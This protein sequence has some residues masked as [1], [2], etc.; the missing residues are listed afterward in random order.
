[1]KGLLETLL[2]Q[3]PAV[4]VTV[5]AA[6]GS[7]PRG[8]GAHMVVGKGGRLYGTVGG[9]RIEARAIET[10]RSVLD[11]GT[12]LCKTESLAP[13]G[14]MG[15]VCGGEAEL[16]YQPLTEADRP[17][18]TAALDALEHE[19]PARLAF[20]RSTGALALMEGPACPSSDALYTES[21][22]PAGRVYIFGGGHVAQALVPVLAAVEFRC[23]VLEDRPEFC[24]RRLFPAA[25]ELRLYPEGQPSAALTAED[26]VCVMTR[27]HRS[28]LEC[29]AFALRSPARYIGVM[30]SRN[31][32][33]TVNARLREMGFT[34]AELARVHT[35]IGLA[36]GAQTPAEIAVSIAAE[37]IAVRAGKG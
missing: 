4:L 29:E 33:R 6:H 12:F 28:D 8:P 7:V 21:L 36:I 32:I 26:Y 16:L 19:R 14:E 9:G 25:Q 5:V 37:L 3:L 11:S 31:K 27:G 17:T 18:L 35:P 10:A 15:M 30:G 2:A 24:D 23:I 1:M 13:G 20:D 34:D 22:A